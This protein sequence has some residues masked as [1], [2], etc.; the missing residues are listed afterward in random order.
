MGCHLPYAIT[1]LHATWHK[2][3]HPTS[4]YL[5]RRDG[6]LNWP[7]W[8]VTYWDSFTVHR[9]SHMQVCTKWDFKSDIIIITLPRVCV[10]VFYTCKYASR[11]PWLVF[12]SCASAWVFITVI[13]WDVVVLAD[14]YRIYCFIHKWTLWSHQWP[15]RLVT[16]AYVVSSPD[17]SEKIFVYLWSGIPYMPD[18]FSLSLAVGCVHFL[19]KAVKEKQNLQL[20][21]FGCIVDIYRMQSWNSAKCCMQRKYVCSF[22]D[23]HGYLIMSLL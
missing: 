15:T 6:R 20:L 10:C 21:L 7:R 23:R 13:T 22:A 2:W 9:W 19:S 5:L 12:C 1:H 17:I 11:M 3:T 4:I 14:L 8:L 16:I 18:I